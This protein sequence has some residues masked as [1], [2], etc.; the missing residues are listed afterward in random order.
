MLSIFLPEPARPASPFYL[1]NHL[2]AFYAIVAL[3]HDKKS[4]AQNKMQ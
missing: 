4:H 3:H 1:A 2:F